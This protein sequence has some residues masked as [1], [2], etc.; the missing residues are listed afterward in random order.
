MTHLAV[1]GAM[2][3]TAPRARNRRKVTDAETVCLEATRHNRPRQRD[4][5]ADGLRKKLAKGL[6]VRVDRPEVCRG[7]EIEAL[8]VVTEPDRLG[9]LEAGLV[10]TEHYDEEVHTGSDSG[11]SRMTCKAVEHEAWQ[12]LPSVAGE[13]S[14]RLAVPA[15]AP[16]S[17]EGSCLSFQWE[18]VARGRRDR[19]LD[20]RASQEISVRP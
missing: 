17:Y 14:V 13:H 4:A 12:P 11:A 18:V 9:E 16:F 8:V 10:C 1:R 3:D 19:K 15:N 5:V 20:A 2:V 6:E 7:E